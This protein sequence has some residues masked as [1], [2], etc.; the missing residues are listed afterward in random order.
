MQLLHLASL[1]V[2]L[3]VVLTAPIANPQDGLESLVEGGILGDLLPDVSGRAAAPV[4]A[5]PISSRQGGLGGIGEGIP[6][7]G[8]IIEDRRAHV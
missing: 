7:L 1:V 4:I 6:I 2:L 5:A 8:G 3:P